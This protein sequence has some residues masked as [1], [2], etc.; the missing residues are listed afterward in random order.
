MTLEEWPPLFLKA[1]R[2]NQTNNSDIIQEITDHI[3]LVKYL[4]VKNNWLY[5]IWDLLCLLFV[6]SGSS[7]V[8][9]FS[10]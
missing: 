8:G 2:T 6:D 9:F 5:I 3:G 7:M 10:W 4:N 1:L